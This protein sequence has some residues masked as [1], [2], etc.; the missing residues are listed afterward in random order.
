MLV[1][2]LFPLATASEFPI[3]VLDENERFLGDIP[4]RKIIES[5]MQDAG[6]ENES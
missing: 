6:E 5:M 2:E 3:A 1:E 4:N